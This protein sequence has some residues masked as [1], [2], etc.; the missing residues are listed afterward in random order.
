MR[1]SLL[2]ILCVLASPAHADPTYILGVIDG[3]SYRASMNGQI[4]TVRLAHADTPEK[5]YRARCDREREMAERATN[6]AAELIGGRTVEVKI[7]AAADRYGRPLVEITTSA[8]R[9]LA[10]QLIAERHAVSYEGR[11]ARQDWCR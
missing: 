6:R 7:L 3:D 4:V 11:G 10:E 9:D 1:L 8:G 5:G 2:A